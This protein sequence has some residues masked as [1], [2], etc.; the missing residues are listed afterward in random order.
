MATEGDSGNPPG[1]GES[2]RAYRAACPGCGAPVLFR[3]A[4]ST[5][6]VCGYCQSTVV[7]D[8]ETL[9][10]IGKMSEVFD[11]Y[12]PLQLFVSG[13]W[14]NRGFTLIGRLQY[15]YAEGSW[16][17]WIANFDDSDGSPESTAT[18]SED[19]G[20]FVMSRVVAA[21]RDVP[22]AEVFKVGATTTIAGKKYTVSSN[23]P[24]SLAAAQGELPKMPPIGAPFAVVELRSDDGEVL[25]IDYGPQAAGRQP[26]LSR[27]QAVELDALALKGLRDESAKDEK[28]QRFDCPNCGAPVEVKLA[29]SKSITCTACNS[30][31]DL[32]QG[33]GAALAHAE[34]DDPVRPVIALGSVGQLQGVQWQVVG[35]QHRMGKAPEDPDESFGWGE[36]LLFNQKK[37]FSFLVDS[38]EG[39]SMV[40]PATGAPTL[41]TNGNVATYLGKRYQRKYSYAAETNYVAG[42]FYWRVQRGQKTFNRDYASGGLLLSMEQSANE[43]TWS[44]GNNLPASTVATAF[45]LKNLKASPPFGDAGPTSL[46]SSITLRGVLITF[47]V[48]VFIAV[49]LSRCDSCD[50]ETENCSSS[51]NSYRNSGG[52][53]GG[54]SGGGGHK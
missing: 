36:Y 27:G 14:Q 35:F 37:G 5:H 33:T 21:Q 24:V 38:E 41:D 39:W 51:G 11:D 48:L 45:G 54:F 46:G 40:K 7:R 12:S 50:P 9:A 47:F 23:E 6:A 10:R 26:T 52:S 34:Q 8:G 31:I 13:R 42:E 53:F 16:N 1:G 15:R 25:S 3:N 2:Q 22:A 19:N 44:Y 29:T 49:A 30:I 32:S 28:G 43:V 17:E 20:S 18:L 4:Q